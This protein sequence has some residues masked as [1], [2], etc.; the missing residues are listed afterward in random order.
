[1]KSTTSNRRL[2]MSIPRSILP[3]LVFISI[4]LCF[5]SGF[6][7]EKKRVA[8]FE[9]KAVGTSPAY[10]EKMFSE[11]RKALTSSK[12]LSMTS[13]RKEEL[14]K[15]LEEMKKAGCSE[16][17]CLTNAGNELDV[18]KIIAGELRQ[19]PEGYFELD[20]RMVDV[21][22]SQ[23][24]QAYQAIKGEQVGDFAKMAEKAV[25][26]IDSKIVIEPRLQYV[27]EGTVFID[28]GADLGVKKGMRFNVLRLGNP[29]KDASGKVI[30]RDDKT[31]GEIEVE[32][33]QTDGS[34]AT[35][36]E[37]KQKFE[38]GDIAKAS[39][40]EEEFDE[41]PKIIH[42]PILASVQGKEISVVANIFDDK[43]VE[44]AKVFYR[45]STEPAFKS[46]PMQNISKDKYTASIPATDIKSGELEY[47][48]AAWDSKGQLCEKKDESR[49]PFRII[50]Q[51][52]KEPPD[53]EHTPIAEIYQSESI[54]LRALIRDNV[55]VA[56]AFVS[57]KKAN[58]EKYSKMELQWQGG[59]AYAAKLP[60]DITQDTK[61]I[62]YYLSAFDQ[63]G[64]SKTFA[65]AAKP[66]E[67]RVNVKDI[68]GPQIVHAPMK[69]Y[70][71]GKDLSISAGV[72]DESGVL[73]V[74]LYIKP[75]YELKY[76]TIPMIKGDKETYTASFSCRFS[77][78]TT[79]RLQYYIVALDSLR[80]E[81]RFGGVNNPYS[82]L[83]QLT[84]LTID[85][86]SP[87]DDTPPFMRHFPPTVMSKKGLGFPLMVEVQD[88]SGVGSVTCFLFNPKYNSYRPIPL[89]KSG[90]P[91]YGEYIPYEGREIKYY[92]ECK[93]LFGNAKMIASPS[94]P[95][96]I[97]PGEIVSGKS[98]YVL[99]KLPNVPP[100]EI[101]FITPNEL[102]SLQT[103]REDIL[104]ERTR[105]LDVVPQ[106]LHVEGL[107]QSKRECDYVFVDTIRANLL[108]PAPS[109]L[110]L[111]KVRNRVI[112]FI[113][114]V[115]MPQSGKTFMVVARDVCGEAT[116]VMLKFNYQ[117][118]P[119]GPQ[120]D[121]IANAPKQKGPENV[122]P[123]K[124]LMRIVLTSPAVEQ[125][126]ETIDVSG[127]R[128]RFKLMGRIEGGSTVS[129]VFVNGKDATITGSKGD[130]ASFEA[131]IQIEDSLNTYVI[132]A[133]GTRAKEYAERTIKFNAGNTPIKIADNLPPTIE[134]FLPFPGQNVSSPAAALSAKITDN[135]KVE[136]ITVLLNS[137]EQS[138]INFRRDGDATLII[139]D[140]LMLSEGVNT[141]E[142]IGSD[143]IQS[144]TK[145]IDI[146]YKK[147]IDLPR[148]FIVSPSTDVVS[149]TP[150][151]L[152]FTVS[153]FREGLKV[154]IKLNDT[155]VYNDLGSGRKAPQDPNRPTEFLCTIV[156]KSGSN[157][158]T[159]S[160]YSENQPIVVEKSFT[161][162]PAAIRPSITILAPKGDVVSEQ[163][164]ELV[165]TVSNFEK[166]KPV[167]VQLND[168]TV[169]P[170]L[171]KKIVLPDNLS[172]PVEF[173]I[174]LVL[175]EGENRIYITARNGDSA[176]I[177]TKKISFKKA[178]EQLVQMEPPKVTITA[179]P[180]TENSTREREIQIRFTVSNVRRDEDVTL[181]LNGNTQQ[182]ARG[183]KSPA[184]PSKPREYV[185]KVTLNEGE[186]I[187]EI[188]VR[189]GMSTANEKRVIVFMPPI[190]NV[191]KYYALLVGVNEYAKNPTNNLQNPI[192]DAGKLR[193][194]L[195]SDYT[196][197]NK[198][199][200][201]LKNPT[202]SEVI[203]AFVA[204]R[205]K[206]QEN[207]NLLIF[208]AGHGTFIKE[209]DQGYWLP[210][211]ADADENPTSWISNGDICDQIR[212][213]K[214]KHV[215]LVTDA[216][217]S[218]SVFKSRSWSSYNSIAAQKLYEKVSRKGMTSGNLTET[219][220]ESKF[221]FYL[222]NSLKSNKEKYLD[223]LTLF[224]DFRN[225]VIANS[226][227]EPQYGEIRNTGDQDGQFIFIRR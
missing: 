154:Q 188:Q 112:K 185:V 77:E 204:V 192:R 99:G 89:R 122:P 65:S 184:D 93:D 17:E 101:T 178:E 217:F 141:I 60:I 123:S 50:I 10:A 183:M 14:L 48:L 170:D 136:K 73:E 85:K 206:I 219:P 153:Y 165:F 150:F 100:P 214:A 120:S 95:I 209:M 187:I 162:K 195:V 26:M 175:R 146:T 168:E 177:E 90:L 167:G 11:L 49:N 62:Q 66:I 22:T 27:T 2:T 172:K 157:K 94:E 45:N 210:T 41:P 200:T 84:Q 161:Y 46:M 3:G 139:K 199:I 106:F 6:A 180:A 15:K 29:I 218:G 131:F 13:E 166:G 21:F 159:I 193:D 138:R 208:Y 114:D 76:S 33:A 196:F 37:Q 44:T 181:T 51:T 142:V 191:G 92:L 216:C 176:Q 171:T 227:T 103:I 109:D 145:S 137:R 105:E 32:T 143:G 129:R 81:Q 39:K 52:D 56:S 108:P 127:A 202:R 211:D 117:T 12:K 107:I 75:D 86:K 34:K 198:D 40:P 69:S 20:L 205:K 223:A 24:E 158:L 4:C 68:Q 135:V 67:I 18:E 80:N 97:V 164:Q 186:N 102:R 215:L 225:A 35:I 128:G 19:M 163:K 111:I 147:L 79:P 190:A 152:R 197:E 151:M 220:D 59:S 121:Q 115:P 55:R 222:L 31:I 155:I 38:V 213:L 148:I 201:F 203:S 7:I 57:F 160:V 224:N 149:E 125:N 25:D 74:A 130:A 134:I 30:F 1:M 156:P 54:Q 124:S 63:G 5:E 116:R 87:L 58:A 221:I 133:E 144:A 173:R 61:I 70:V 126:I 169:D 83:P 113:C 119:G 212:S 82:V 132:V 182:T 43:K 179:P 16:A 36:I 42:S 28:A 78:G 110:S 72:K 91:W 47:Y 226:N 189:N 71:P 104:R 64:N 88:E 140:T 98:N 23:Y 96:I 9:I 118:S 174:S 207:D 53:I 194:V 8:L